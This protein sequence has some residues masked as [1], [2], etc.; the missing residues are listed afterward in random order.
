MPVVGSNG[1]ST[2]PPVTPALSS[3][4]GGL[5]PHLIATL[6]E[7]DI[8]GK[9]V[10]ENVT[11]KAPLVGSA[12]LGM[13]MQWQSPFESSG[14]ES[15]AP[16][17]AAM[18]QSGALIPAIDSING[19]L[20]AGGIEVSDSFKSSLKDSLN[21]AIGRTGLTKLNS[22]QTFA[23][24]PPV[25]LTCSFLL[26]AWRDPVEEVMKPLEQI[27]K[28]LLPQKLADQSTLL[29]RAADFAAGKGG[30]AIDV[31]LPSKSPV[32]IAMRYAGMTYSPLVI[33]SASYDL[34]APKDKN[35]NFVSQTIPLKLASLT[36]IDKDDFVGFRK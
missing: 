32:M 24:M 7:V 1:K 36:A 35:G 14:A 27:M 8:D 5:S 28:W 10:D 16:M 33:E 12:V 29:T 22:T 2:K 25:D 21:S 23:G 9:R 11:V 3:E 19:A 20:K 17:L 34:N 30:S 15:K 13:Q 4:W 18:L 26:R 6:Y 31:L